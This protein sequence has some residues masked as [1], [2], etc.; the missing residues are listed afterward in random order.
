MHK[1]LIKKT[2][3]NTYFILLN[4]N[5]LFKFFHNGGKIKN[6]SFSFHEYFILFCILTDYGL[7]DDI[8]H[9]RQDY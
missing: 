3:N 5:I 6:I 1:I 2:S 4:K 7:Y 8:Y 9:Y